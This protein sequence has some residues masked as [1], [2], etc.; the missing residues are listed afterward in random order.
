MLCICAIV[1]KELR[2]TKIDKT[3]K[4]YF[5]KVHVC[6]CGCTYIRVRNY[7]NKTCEPS[8]PRFAHLSQIESTLSCVLYGTNQKCLKKKWL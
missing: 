1:Y 6:V 2:E 7:Y 3:T 4:S 8:F 5:C